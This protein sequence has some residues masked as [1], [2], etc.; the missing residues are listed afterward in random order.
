MRVAASRNLNPNSCVK[1][2]P[3]VVNTP[4]Q[5]LNEQRLNQVLSAL[6]NPNHPR[7]VHCYDGYCPDPN[8][9]NAVSQDDMRRKLTFDTDKVF[10]GR[11]YDPQSYNQ[12][13]AERFD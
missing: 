12:K 5:M 7:P 6:D 13:D 4:F 2:I 8:D 9:E 3:Q 10:S 1:G 11:V